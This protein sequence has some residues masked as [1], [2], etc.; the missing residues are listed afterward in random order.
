MEG[1]LEVPNLRGQTLFGSK[2]FKSIHFW[3]TIIWGGIPKDL[4]NK[5]KVNFLGG[6]S[7]LGFQFWCESIILWVN[8]NVILGE[9]TG[10]PEQLS[11]VTLLSLACFS[12][13]I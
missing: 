9:F 7:F 1:L 2:Y 5:F 8:Q 6:Y 10:C 3:I 4:V 13:Y 11:S 12:L